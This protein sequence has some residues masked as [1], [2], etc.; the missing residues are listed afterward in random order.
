MNWRL[1]AERG[2]L[3]RRRRRRP[4]AATTSGR[5]RSRSSSTSLWPLLLLAV[6]CVARRAR[7][8]ARPA[9]R[10]ARS[11]SRRLV[12]LRRPRT[13][14]RAGAGVLLGAG[15]RLGAR[16]SAGC[17]PS[18]CS[19]RG[20]S[21]PRPPRA[22]ALG[23]RRGD[24][25]RDAGARR[26]RRAMPG[27]PALLP[28]LGAVALLAAGTSA[29]AGA[30]DARAD[31]AARALRRARSP[32][33]GTSGT[34]RCWCSPRPAGARCRRREGV[35]VSLA[36]LVPALVTHRWIEEPLRRS[37]AHLRAAAPILVAALAGPAAA[38]ASGV[39]LSASLASPAGAVAPAE[40]EGARPARAHRAHPGVG[41]GA[42][43]AP[44]R[45]ER[46]RGEPYATAASS[47]SAATRSPRCVYGAR[48]SR[49]HRRAVRRLARDAAVPGARAVALR[50]RWRLVNLTKAGCPPSACVRRLAALAPAYP[51]C[52]AW[53]EYALRRIEREERPAL[54]LGGAAPRTTTV[55]AGERGSAATRARARSRDGWRAGA[56]PAA[57][58]RRP[59]VVLTDPPRAAARRPRLRVRAPEASCAAARSRAARRR[60]ARGRSS[61][62]LRAGR[63][64]PRARPDGASSASRT[65][66]RA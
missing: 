10:A 18:R 65:C 5:W 11:R 41:D 50:R 20:G 21:A 14:R 22:A 47:T 51:E 7:P 58:R 34:G 44:A 13:G 24:R 1:S 32:T 64:R 36:S 53:R 2:R 45:R 29:R 35:A 26:R 30:A 59:V 63:R 40:A 66:A 19:A 38:V 54:V 3:L 33:P 49:D 28:V 15:A 25:R 62:A 8:A 61:D 23:R 39:A 43:P 52:D 12:R 31:H 17:W 57:R 9:R 42:A 6:A 37:K 55:L 16:G 4:P 27:A 56:A 48:R 46:D 60:R